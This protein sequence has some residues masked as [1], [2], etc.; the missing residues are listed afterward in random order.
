MPTLH[1]RRFARIA[2]AIM[3]TS[4]FHVIS[5]CSNRITVAPLGP[6]DVVPVTS[7]TAFPQPRYR[8]EPGDVLRIRFPLHPE[9][10]QDVTVRPDGRVDV[11]EVGEMTVGALAP[12]EVERAL[13]ERTHERLRDG[14]AE[15]TI[16]TFAPR[17]VYV[18]GEVGRP[19][20]IPYRRGLSPLQAVLQA[21]GFA[22]TACLSCVV[23][24]RAAESNGAFVS[25]QLDLERAVMAGEPET[26]ELAPR[27]VIYVPRTSIA[28]TD[29]WVDQYVT[30]LFPFLR[31]AGA[32]FGL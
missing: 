18:T 26:L 24:V 9:M 19:G 7:A 31:G 6:G 11:A 15:V 30:R 1:T 13:R 25:R 4:V 12:E 17:S 5:G 23:V 2:A 3:V 29:L 14:R 28:E 22:P 21:G 32:S 27:D 20:A 10:D 16:T 8:V